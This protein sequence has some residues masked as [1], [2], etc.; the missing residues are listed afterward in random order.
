MGGCWDA[1]G[2]GLGRGGVGWI[3]GRDVC[4]VL[5]VV[6]TSSSVMRRNQT[7]WNFTRMRRKWKGRMRAEMSA[8]V[9]N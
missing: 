7:S 3:G 6:R 9:V 4:G 1:G 8:V 2:V 5:V